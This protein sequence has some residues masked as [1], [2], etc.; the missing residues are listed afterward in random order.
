MIGAFEGWKVPPCTRRRL[1]D[2]QRT[3]ATAPRPDD[4]TADS[5]DDV[6]GHSVFGALAVSGALRSRT[7]QDGDKARNK[8]D[9]NL[10]PIT[11]SFPSM[12]DGRRK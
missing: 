9:E 5:G 3:D 6:E 8:T 12:R 2:D 10:P 4:N 1:M 11:K 7:P